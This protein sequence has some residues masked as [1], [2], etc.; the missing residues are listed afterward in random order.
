ML[1]YGSLGF[2]VVDRWSRLDGR[3][4]DYAEG[5]C[6]QGANFLCGPKD[7]LFSC[8]PCTADSLKV[9]KDLQGQLNRL[10]VAK[11]LPR[12]LLLD[13][14]GRFGP[15][16]MTTARA[17]AVV[18]GATIPASTEEGARW[19][20]TRAESVS[21]E[22]KTAADEAGAPKTPPTP[23]KDIT[24]TPGPD[25][26]SLPAPARGNGHAGLIIGGLALLAA[27]GLVASAAYA[28]KKR[29]R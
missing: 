16:T 1:S 2:E 7:G 6:A 21:K 8:R 29:R 22:L 24:V 9:F 10:V 17:V 13:I 3:F 28:K 4:G 18:T 20:A 26:A 11:N 19:L 12:T 25:A 27:G 15:R 23:P 14:D 5:V